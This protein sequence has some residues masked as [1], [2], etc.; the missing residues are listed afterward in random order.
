MTTP[1][2]TAGH[3][4]FSTTG[5]PAGP[6]GPAPAPPLR[7]RVGSHELAYALHGQASDKLPVLLVMGFSLPGRGW[8]FVW[9]G[10]SE[11]R[12]VVSFDNRG[13]GDS[14]KPPGPYAMADFSADTLALADHLGFDR[15]H[16][17]GVSMG[18]MIAQHIALTARHRLASLSL[19]ATHPGGFL[20]RLPRLQGIGTFL[21]ANLTKVPERRYRAIASMLFPRAFIESVGEERLME[22]LRHDFEPPIPRHARR[23]QLAAIFAH[24]TRARLR[25]LADLPTLIVEPGRDVLIHPKNSRRLHALIPN[26]RLVRMPDAGHGLIRQAGDEVARLLRE[27]TD[28]AEAVTTRTARA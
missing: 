21:S 12:L 9:P 16:L 24:D 5:A 26:S 27:H 3:A 22:V 6:G 25:E 10:L 18:G 13:A 4:L 2:P 11:D 17:V 28:R 1:A 8:R 19:I 7:A 20:A 15:F 23:A 14:D